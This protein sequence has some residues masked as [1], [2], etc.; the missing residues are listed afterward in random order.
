M[1]GGIYASSG[2]SH[3]GRGGARQ[4]SRAEGAAQR[5]AERWLT[6]RQAQRRELVKATTATLARQRLEARS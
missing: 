2:H 6:K 3:G 1:A 5:R 4:R